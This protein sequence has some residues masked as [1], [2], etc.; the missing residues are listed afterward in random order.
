MFSHLFIFGSAS[1]GLKSGFNFGPLKKMHAAE[2]R[3]FAQYC[4]TYTGENPGFV[5]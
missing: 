2:L 3:D 4:N 1:D 5:P